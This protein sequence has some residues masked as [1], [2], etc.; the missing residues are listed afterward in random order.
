MHEARS[1]GDI[2]LRDLPPYIRGGDGSAN[3][4]LNGFV[5]NV[6][7]LYCIWSIDHP[8]NHLTVG[9]DLIFILAHQILIFKYSKDET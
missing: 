7:M 3:A 6:F 2:E 4:N 9:H 1:K 5:A 8:Q